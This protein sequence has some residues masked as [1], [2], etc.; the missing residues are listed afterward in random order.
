MGKDNIN[1]HHPILISE[2]ITFDER[3]DV[4]RQPTPWVEAVLYRM[5]LFYAGN[6]PDA[7]GYGGHVG[8]NHP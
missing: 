5:G 7:A 8:G 3:P 2:R 1:F 6:V 4:A